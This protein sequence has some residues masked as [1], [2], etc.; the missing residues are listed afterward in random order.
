MCVKSVVL[1]YVRVRN[2][3]GKREAA[4]K[5]TRKLWNAP[6]L[7]KDAAGE[8]NV[9]ALYERRRSKRNERARRDTYKKTIHARRRNTDVGTRHIEAQKRTTINSGENRWKELGRPRTYYI[10]CRTTRRCG[11]SS[12]TSASRQPGNSG[13]S[14]T[15]CKTNRKVDYET[16]NKNRINNYYRILYTHIRRR[17]RFF[18]WLTEARRSKRCTNTIPCQI[19]RLSSGSRRYRVAFQ[20]RNI[21]KI[22]TMFSKQ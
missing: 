7:E 12:H 13:E 16:K 20:L 17:E 10:V 2:L 22:R 4:Q 14:I 21:Q 3:D 8:L 1:H 6:V 5:N 18:C 19:Y 15:Y 9:T 11:L